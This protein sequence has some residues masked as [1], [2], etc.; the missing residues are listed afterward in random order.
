MEVLR[1]EDVK[2]KQKG[3][4]ANPVLQKIMKITL[5]TEKNTD[6]CKEITQETERDNAAVF[7][8]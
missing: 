2:G 8:Y 5:E 4:K 7:W 3:N 6:L 1:N